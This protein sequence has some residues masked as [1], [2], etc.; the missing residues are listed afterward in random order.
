MELA[1]IALSGLD[2]AVAKLDRSARHVAAASAVGPEGSSVDT[3]DLAVAMVGLMEAR[4]E[5]TAN[6][7]VIRTADEMTKRTL[8]ILA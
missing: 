1:R 3:V 6:V 7:Q 4:Q 5:F 2:G 8:D